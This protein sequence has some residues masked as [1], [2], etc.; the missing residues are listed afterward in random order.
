LSRS[1]PAPQVCIASPLNCYASSTE[2]FVEFVLSFH[3]IR[4]YSV[5]NLSSSPTI[6]IM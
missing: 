1:V 4:V 6:H 2:Y 5:F 3:I